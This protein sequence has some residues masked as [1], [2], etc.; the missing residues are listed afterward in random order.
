MAILMKIIELIFVGISSI[1]IFILG[2]RLI[3]WAIEHPIFRNIKLKNRLDN[4]YTEEEIKKAFW[5][6]FHR[7][8]EWVFP[9]A[10][11]Y[12]HETV[13]EINASWDEFKRCLVK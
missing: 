1:V 2:I 9:Y 6:M 12:A 7:S 3:I 4:V 13:N 11:E 8:G 10:D 5:K